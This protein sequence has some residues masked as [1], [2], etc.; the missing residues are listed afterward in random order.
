MKEIKEGYYQTGDVVWLPNYGCVATEN[1]IG[2]YPIFAPIFHALNDN[3]WW[4]IPIGLHSTIGKEHAGFCKD[5]NCYIQH[6]DLIE[7]NQLSYYK[8][9]IKDKEKVQNK[10][11]IITGPKTIG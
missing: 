2:I 6:I 8:T 1:P 11:K 4:L 9:S 7:D 10:L 3:D 5:D